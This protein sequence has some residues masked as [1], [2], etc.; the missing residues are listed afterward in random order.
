MDLRTVTYFLILVACGRISEE[1]MIPVTKHELQ[2]F[3]EPPVPKIGTDCKSYLESMSQLLANS[4]LDA[5]LPAILTSFSYGRSDEFVGEIRWFHNMLKCFKTSIEYNGTRSFCFGYNSKQFVDLRAFAICIPR[6]CANDKLESTSKF[7]TAAFNSH[8]SLFIARTVTKIAEVTSLSVEQFQLSTQTNIRNFSKLTKLPK[9]QSTIT[10]MFGLRVYSMVWTLIG[11]SFSWIQAYVENSDEYRF[12]MAG[13]FWNLLITNFNLAVDTFF[14]LS[15]TL[16]SY[17]WFKSFINGAS[18]LF[19]NIPDRKVPT[20]RSW[21]YWLAF[22][23]HRLIRLWP[24]YLYALSLTAFFLMELG[25]HS[26]W[27]PL[28]QSLQCRENGWQ[29]ALFLNSLMCNDCMGWTYIGTEFIFYMISP[30][31]LLLLKYSPQLGVSLSLTTVV[32]SSLMKLRIMK[33]DNYPPIPLHFGS[34]KFFRG[35]FM[36]VSLCNFF[37]LYDMFLCYR[38]GQLYVYYIK[39]QYRISPYI[40]GLLLGHK[41]ADFRKRTGS[42]ISPLSQFFGWLFCLIL[43]CWSIFGAYPTMKDIDAPIFN[44]FYGSTHRISWA[45]AVAWI[46]YACHT[47]VGGLVDR[48]LSHKNLILFSSLSYSVYLLHLFVVFGTFM[49]SPF[50]I[51]FKSKI[52][53]LLLAVPQLFLSYLAALALSMCT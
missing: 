48:I 24:A 40:I 21:R 23:R 28:D 37:S 25:S 26:M 5:D 13:Y 42:S 20:W 19:L 16:N 3:F 22:Y 35:T 2:A 32:L 14:V 36:E 49:W 45:V 52:S 34:S 17:L 11:H 15:A 33:N 47:G 18:F 41:L 50:P 6:Q 46:I 30:I 31:F 12:H 10:C 7:D 51:K 1:T 27:P 43:G 39:P 44:L 53:I 4:S 8:V 38:E 29:N 9:D